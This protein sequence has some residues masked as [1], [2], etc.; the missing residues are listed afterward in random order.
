MLRTRTCSMGKL[1][2][3]FY[4]LNAANW[5]QKKFI[6]KMYCFRCD[7]WRNSLGEIRIKYHN[8]Y[9]LTNSIVSFECP[10]FN[11]QIPKCRSLYRAYEIYHNYLVEWH[12]RFFPKI[13]F[14]IWNYIWT[15]IPHAYLI[16]YDKMCDF[17]CLLT[18]NYT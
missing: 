15:Q 18:L 11:H 14:I 10:S 16:E 9:D 12:Q 8:K 3:E 7:N 17:V 4:T 5:T 1:N 2:S 6:S 13:K